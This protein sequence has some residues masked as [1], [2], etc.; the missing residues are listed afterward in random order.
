MSKALLGGVVVS[1]AL[2]LQACASGGRSAHTPVRVVLDYPGSGP[3]AVAVRDARPDVVGGSRKETFIGLQRSLYGIPYA[4]QTSSGKPF[5]AEIAAM[6]ER[7]LSAQKVDAEVVEASPFA[8]RDETINALAGTGKPR[9]LLFEISEWYS[10]T[11]ARATLHYEVSLVVLDQEGRELG[12]ST[13]KGEDDIGGRERAERK[14]IQIATEDIFRTLLKARDV[15]AS[16]DPEAKPV[17]ER[18]TC[19]ADQ[20]LQMQRSGLSQAQIKAACGEG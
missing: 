8:P 4:V 13:A 7:G 9:L 14:T 18:G 20:I 1:A 16:L 11:Y 19:T 2:L 5:A 6:L 3:V 10:D 12:R 15:V 17:Q